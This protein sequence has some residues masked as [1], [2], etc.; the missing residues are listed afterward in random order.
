MKSIKVRKYYIFAPSN[1]CSGGPEA[2]HQL[3]YYMCNVGCDAY[4]V[5][6]CSIGFLYSSTISRYQQYNSR[7]IEYSKIEDNVDNICI[8]PENAPWCLNG[9]YNAKKIIMWLGVGA[10][11]VH[12]PN[13]KQK[14]IYLKRRM[15]SQSLVNARFI[16]YDDSKCIHLCGSKYAFEYVSKKYPNSRVR[17]LVEPISKDFYNL[18]NNYDIKQRRKDIVL[19]NPSKPSERMSQLLE[20]AKYEYIPLKGYTPIEL[21]EKYKEAK[22]YIDLGRF[23]GPERMPKEA[24]YFGCNILVANHN[25]AANDFDVAIPND[26]KI[27]DMESVEQIEARFAEMLCHYEQHYPKFGSFRKKIENLEETYLQQIKEIFIDGELS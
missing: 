19:Y 26:Y 27:D 11:Q 15:L 14:I 5:Y 9:I 12:Y 7:V 6:Y 23:D 25:A 2:L 4:I 17:Y 16:L 24:V 10:N 3:A 22:L 18:G 13:I 20:R 21:A 1:C 8:A